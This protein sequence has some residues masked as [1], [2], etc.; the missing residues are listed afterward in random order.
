MLKQPELSTQAPFTS[1]VSA[2]TSVFGLRAANQIA[3]ASAM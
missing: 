1:P 2:G 3:V